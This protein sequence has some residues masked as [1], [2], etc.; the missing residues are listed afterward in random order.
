MTNMRV[1]HLIYVLLMNL[2]YFVRT[3]LWGRRMTT[4][5]YYSLFF[6]ASLVSISL[7]MLKLKLTFRANWA[8]SLMPLLTYYFLFFI[9]VTRLISKNTC[10]LKE[11]LYCTSIMLFIIN[12]VL[13]SCLNI[14]LSSSYLSLWCSI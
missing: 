11:S 4:T 2:L 8:L 13:K 3:W 6:A 12:L 9:I 1:R 5:F 14:S 10:I 7:S